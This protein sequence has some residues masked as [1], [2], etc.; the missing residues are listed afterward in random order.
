MEPE[1]I[2]PGELDDAVRRY[3]LKLARRYVP[4]VAIVVVLILILVLVPRVDE[5]KQSPARV[6]S[7]ASMSGAASGAWLQF[8]KPETFGPEHTQL[9]CF[10]L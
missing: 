8:A 3:V 10:G 1:P 6:G 4:L 9:H 2:P 7:G 5:Q